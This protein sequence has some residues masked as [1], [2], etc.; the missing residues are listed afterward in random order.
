MASDRQALSYKES[1]GLGYILSCFIILF[2][3]YFLFL[4][5]WDNDTQSA[6]AFQGYPLV[7]LVVGQLLP[8]KVAQEEMPYIHAWMSFSCTAC[9]AAFLVFAGEC[10]ESILGIWPFTSYARKTATKNTVIWERH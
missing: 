5:V 8:G 1:D 3:F 10:S 7:L 6:E 4:S 9:G 2:Y